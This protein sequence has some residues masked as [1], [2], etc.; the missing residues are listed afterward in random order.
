VASW[1]LRGDGVVGQAGSGHG[2]GHR[3]RDLVARRVRRAADA[4]GHAAGGR[5]AWLGGPVAPGHEDR[6][7]GGEADAAVGKHLGAMDAH[8]DQGAEEVVGLGGTVDGGE[9][10]HDP[11]ARRQG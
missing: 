1:L 5:G 7:V 9:G 6:V 8:L 3:R 2:F 4:D 11:A 10:G